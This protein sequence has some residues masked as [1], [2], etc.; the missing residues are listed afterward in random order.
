MKPQGEKPD[1]F[2][3]SI[4]QV[5]LNVHLEAISFVLNSRIQ[6]CFNLQTSLCDIE[7]TN[8]L[9]VI[10]LSMALNIWGGGQ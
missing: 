1:E 3:S 8:L 4:S 5:S 9:N 2:E 7:I 6:I 10:G